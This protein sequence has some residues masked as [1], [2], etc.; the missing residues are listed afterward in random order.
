MA[1]SVHIP[2][3]L[4]AAVDRKA[5]TLRVSRNRLIIAALEKEVAQGSDWPAGFFEQFTPLDDGTATALD[6]SMAK[7]KSARRSKRLLDL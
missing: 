7:V 4:L 1:T 3:P 6:E 5:R 2:G